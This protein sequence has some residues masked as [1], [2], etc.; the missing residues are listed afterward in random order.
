ML[1]LS[2]PFVPVV[3]EKKKHGKKSCKC[4]MKEFANEMGV[5]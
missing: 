1:A 4:E 5:L 3:L 2:L